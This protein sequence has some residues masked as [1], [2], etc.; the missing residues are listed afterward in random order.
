[1]KIKRNNEIMYDV[2]GHH[3]CIAE[4]TFCKVCP[5]NRIINVIASFMKIIIDVNV[6]NNI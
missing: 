2:W 4:Q 1:M 6:V 5:I 3:T